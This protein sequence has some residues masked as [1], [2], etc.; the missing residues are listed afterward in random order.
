[1]T[2]L[3]YEYLD[4]DVAKWL[5]A[6]APE[7]RKGRNWHQYV[8]DQYG[9]RK[10]I[11]HIWMLIGIASTC[12]NISDLYDRMAEKYGRRRRSIPTV[13]AATTMKLR[14]AAALALCALAIW[15]AGCGTSNPSQSLQQRQWQVPGS[16]DDPDLYG[17]MKHRGR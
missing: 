5:K 10:L 16:L 3:V 1:V 2:Q 8:S 11:E 17:Q 6:N 14:H 4:L 9:L 13:L 7:P 12:R 15:I